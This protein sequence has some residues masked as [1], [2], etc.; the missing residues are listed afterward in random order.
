M[1]QDN[2]KKEHGEEKMKRIIKKYHS[3][4]TSREKDCD[5][6]YREEKSHR[7]PARGTD[8]V[9][10]PLKMIMEKKIL[11]QVIINTQARSILLADFHK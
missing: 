2:S 9:A 7:R 4:R 8:L 3:R 11:I 5:N 1:E 10:L 6:D